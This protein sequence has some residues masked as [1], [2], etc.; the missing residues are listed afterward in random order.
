VK[1]L[2]TLG[3][4]NYDRRMTRCYKLFYAKLPFRVSELECRCQLVLQVLSDKFQISEMAIFVEK[5]GKVED[6]LDE[7]RKEFK[8]S[9]N[10]TKQLRLVQIGTTPS[11]MRVFKV[12]SSDQ[13]FSEVH[14]YT[15][16]H[17]SFRVEE[18]P[19]DQLEIE[20]NEHLLAVAHFDKEPSRMFGVPFFIKIRNE[21][22]ISNIRERIKCM[23][24]VPER[25]FEK[26]KFCIV[27]HN[28]VVRELDNDENAVV[29]L[30]ELA[31]THFSTPTPIAAPYLGIDHIN[32]SRGMRGGHAAEKAIVIHN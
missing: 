3:V 8:Y 5:R 7:A 11:L 32:K 22:R 25:E 21:E 12:L 16:P 19:S 6:V 30:S 2:L 26:Y 27:M 15:S 28:R 4:Q 23:L 20:Q 14:G 24:E 17:F 1:D 10:G 18:T 13:L 31:Q 29:K 9:E